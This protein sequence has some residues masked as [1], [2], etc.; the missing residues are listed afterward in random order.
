MTTA[1]LVGANHAHQLPGNPSGRAD[2]FREF[3]AQQARACRVDLIAEEM[4]REALAKWK[5]E[6]SSVQAAA[7]SV[8]VKH[9]LCDPDSAERK[10]LGIPSYEEL[11]AARGASHLSGEDEELLKNDER[12]YWPIREKEWLKRVANINH[13]RVLFVIGP[14]HVESFSFLLQE[15]CYRVQVLSVRWEA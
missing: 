14:D 3:V 11:K 1:V 13:R 15:A 8:H 6:K 2:L 7:E 10:A 5:V 9:L 4:S 12:T